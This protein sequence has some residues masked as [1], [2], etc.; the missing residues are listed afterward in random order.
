MLVKTAKR[1]TNALYT[2]EAY[3]KASTKWIT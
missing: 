2:N 1:M 3:T